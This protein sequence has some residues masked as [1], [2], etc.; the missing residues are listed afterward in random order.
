MKYTLFTAVFAVREVNHISTP[1]LCRF[2]F[3]KHRGH[4]ACF[5]DVDSN[6]CQ[7]YGQVPIHGIISHLSLEQVDNTWHTSSE[8]G[9]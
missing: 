9:C 8:D 1:C 5:Q 3:R 6:W 4:L 2:T 7:Q